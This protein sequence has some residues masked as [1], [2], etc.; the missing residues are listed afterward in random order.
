MGGTE[1]E[2]GRNG[3]E[4][5]DAGRDKLLVVPRSSGL[6]YNGK[7]ISTEFS[8]GGTVLQ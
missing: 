3:K 6:K 4:M 1:G 2:A 5:V 8:E 7:R